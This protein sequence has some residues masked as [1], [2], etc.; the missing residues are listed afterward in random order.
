[1]NLEQTDCLTKP[2]ESRFTN[3]KKDI[4]TWLRVE[5]GV[6]QPLPNNHPNP[7]YPPFGLGGWW[8]PPLF[9]WAGLSYW[10]IRVAVGQQRGPSLT[11]ANFQQK[12]TMRPRLLLL[13][14]RTMAERTAGILI[15]AHF[16][17][18]MQSTLKPGK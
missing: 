12:E 4:R 17:C 18:W 2:H 11:L 13:I 15:S 16:L 10:G 14:F 5:R 6:S 8:W 7:L 3:H 9:W 1:M